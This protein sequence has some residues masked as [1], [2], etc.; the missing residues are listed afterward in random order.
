MENQPAWMSRMY[1][2]TS[3]SDAPFAPPTATHGRQSTQGRS[4]TV[5][6]RRGATTRL[7]R[8][9]QEGAAKVR[10]PRTVGEP[11][12]AVVINTA[13]GLTGGDQMNVE[14]ALLA[15]ARAVLTTQACERIYR[16]TGDEAEVMTHLNVGPGARLEWLPQET[17]L[18]DDG[19]LRRSLDAELAEDAQ[20]LVVES[21][22][23]GRHAMG[24]RV[25]RGLLHDRWRIRRGGQLIFADELRFEDE[26]AE[27]ASRKAVL[28]GQAAVATVISVGPDCEGALDEVRGVLA[29]SGGASAWNGKLLV[30]MIA[31][32]GLALR[33][34]LFAVLSVLTDGRPLPKVWR[35]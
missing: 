5:F 25:R 31:S 1:V 7:D 12:E 34:T 8:L 20:L 16:S 22:I 28:S 10:L 30:R 29:G 26:I 17:I 32:D 14:V 2:D 11:A 35:L 21:F 13:G 3:C 19:R 27:L 18:F 6:R 23:F 15:G 9:Y 24:E 33:Q 4:R